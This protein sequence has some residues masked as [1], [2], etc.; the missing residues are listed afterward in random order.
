MTYLRIVPPLLL[1]FA[2]PAYVAYRKGRPYGYGRAW[3]WG[4]V[5]VGSAS[6]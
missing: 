2:L 4:S 3:M 6:T 1:W 5:P